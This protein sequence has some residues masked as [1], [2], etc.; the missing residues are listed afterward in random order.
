MI[1]GD[2]A[3][4]R[5]AAVPRHRPG[6]KSPGYSRSFLRNGWNQLALLELYP[7]LLQRILDSSAV[8]ADA[9]LAFYFL[10]QFDHAAG[11]LDQDDARRDVPQVHALL[12]V[13]VEA[14]GGDVGEVERGGAHR[15]KL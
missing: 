10:F 2:Q 14:S 13:G 11:L 6:D 12:D 1:G 7:L 15:A 5:D 4:L 3:S 8:G 9:V